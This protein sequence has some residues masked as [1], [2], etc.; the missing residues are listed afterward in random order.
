MAQGE[1]PEIRRRDIEESVTF[2]AEAGPFT[3]R[4]DITGPTNGDTWDGSLQR[5][6]AVVDEAAE[7]TAYLVKKTGL[8]GWLHSRRP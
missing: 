7:D 1:L 6:E 3:C 4:C 5:A 8:Y 2:E